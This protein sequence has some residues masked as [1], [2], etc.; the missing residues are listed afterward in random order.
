[1][2]NW[3]L[4]MKLNSEAEARVIQSR[5]QA[6]GIDTQLLGSQSRA[7]G[8]IPDMLR[9][10]VEPKNLLQAKSILDGSNDQ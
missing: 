1:M 9:I 4:L 2:E 5:L 6:D 7:A 10:M 8:L 3:V